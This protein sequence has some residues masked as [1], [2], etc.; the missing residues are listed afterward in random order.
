M[1]MN[2][3]IFTQ[4]KAAIRLARCAVALALCAGCS[5]K[6]EAELGVFQP[7]LRDHDAGAAGTG[8]PPS[9]SEPPQLVL[10]VSKT[11]ICPGECIE[12]SAT[13]SAGR[14][15]YQYHWDQDA[16]GLEGPGPH[17]LCP[18]AAATYFA[19]VTDADFEESGVEVGDSIQVTLR[20]TCADQPDAGEPVPPLQ[21]PEPLAEP[22]GGPLAIVIEASTTEICAG[23]CVDLTAVASG[24]RAP[25]DYNWEDGFEGAGPHEVCP[26]ATTTYFAS[27]FD[28]DFSESHLEVGATQQITVTGSCDP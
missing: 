16:A 3:P 19:T 13:A 25:Y 5:P 27:V 1:D 9:S 17:H 11:E 21:E 15:P 6:G 28:A 12:L 24:G 7:E 20:A 23:E 4:S 26:T 10:A 18:E 2:Q 22:S 14:A 8:S